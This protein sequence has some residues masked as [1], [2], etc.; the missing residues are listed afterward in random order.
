MKT[1]K[2]SGR[3]VAAE[4]KAQPN[5]ESLIGRL[6]DIG[7]KDI[8]GATKGVA[9]SER[10][11]CKALAEFVIPYAQEIE[12]DYLSLRGLGISK[13]RVLLPKAR[14]AA[15]CK[16][17]DHFR[18]LFQLAAEKTV[19]RLRKALS[20]REEPPIIAQRHYQEGSGTYVVSVELSREEVEKFEDLVTNRFE[21]RFETAT[22][23]STRG[24]G[25][26]A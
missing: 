14:R 9:E 22:T 25:N 15:K 24:K 18:S 3:S 21:W 7:V 5:Y 23:Q 26:E 8:E 11:E 4:I 12:I 13:L 20:P 19:D 16:Q 1:S 17:E 2:S 10:F 6:K